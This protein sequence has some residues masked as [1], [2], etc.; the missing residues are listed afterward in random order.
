MT[1]NRVLGLA[2]V[3]CA[4][5]LAA[6]CGG[7]GS[8]SSSQ[9]SSTDQTTDVTSPTPVPVTQSSGPTPISIAFDQVAVAS[10]AGALKVDMSLK[11]T[12]KDPI[13]CDPSEFSLQLGTAS[14]IDADTSAA[15]SC[16]PDSIDPDTTGKAT[17]F[18]NVPGDYKGPVTVII[19]VGD[20]V[21]GQ[22]TTQV[23]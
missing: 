2:T 18:F 17:M 11:N 15:D 13:Q 23:Q 5:A 8:S 14:P 7:Q 12:S 16:D 22:G 9:S 21:V 3:I 4:A 6:G 10:G 20:A 1:K 19:T